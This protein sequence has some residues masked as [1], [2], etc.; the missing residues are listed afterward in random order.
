MYLT[1]PA[2]SEGTKKS[3]LKLRFFPF[4]ATFNQKSNSR[5]IAGLVGDLFSSRWGFICPV[6][7]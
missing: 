4:K 5:A 6:A 3:S 7:T 2:A 1:G